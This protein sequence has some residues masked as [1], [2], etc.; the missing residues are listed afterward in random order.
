MSNCPK[1][2]SPEV[3]ADTP[4]TVYSCG[5]SDYDRRDGTFTDTEVCVV[6]RLVRATFR[7]LD[8]SEENDGGIS[9]DVRI[10][11]SALQEISAA[12]DALGIESL[13]DSLSVLASKN[14]ENK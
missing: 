10:S 9:I 11:A 7:L 14:Q 1:C 12:L 5:A 13:N 2:K 4:R 6:R 8:D 3:D